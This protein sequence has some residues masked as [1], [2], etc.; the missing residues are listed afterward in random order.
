[1]SKF[2]GPNYY[3]L[4]TYFDA[5]K[6]MT[7]STNGY[8]IGPKK[9]LV[10][11]GGYTVLYENSP[12][13]GYVAHNFTITEIDGNRFK[14]TYEGLESTFS[15]A[16]GSTFD[17]G[18]EFY[19]RKD[20]TF[21]AWLSLSENEDY[22]NYCNQ[23][24]TFLYFG[25]IWPDSSSSNSYVIEFEGLKDFT[26][27]CLP[28]HNQ[29]VGM[30]EWLKVYWDRVHHEVYSMTKNFWSMMDAR[31]IDI[32]W[33]GYIAGIYGIEIT[34]DVLNEISLR[35]W[36]ENLP[37]FLKRVGTYDAL[38]IVWKV[39]VQNTQNKLN[40]YERWGEWCTQTRDAS[41]GGN[42]T[43]TFV[44]HHF[45]EFYGTQPSG[46][47]GDYYYSQYDPSNYPVHTQTAPSTCSPSVTGNY[48]LTPHYKVQLD[49]STEPLGDVFDDETIIS[50]NVITE[51]YNNFE[52]VRPVN[53]YVH[54][55]ELIAPLGTLNNKNFINLYPL[56]SEGYFN[57]SFT[58]YYGVSGG[59]GGEST[60]E[61]Y[62]AT[63]ATTW[64]VNHDLDSPYVIVQVWEI[65]EA[66]SDYRM[67][68]PDEIR[69]IDN[70]NL[71]I[72]FADG[73]RNGIA[74][75][76]GHAS[77]AGISA[78]GT[79]PSGVSWNMVHSLDATTPEGYT[80]NVGPVVSFY[81]TNGYKDIPSESTI[82]SDSTQTA[83][84]AIPQSGGY[85]IRRSE[86]IH[87]QPTSASSWSI[88]HNLS[89]Y[90]IVQ[91]YDWDT[92][93]LIFPEE[94]YIESSTQY[95]KLTINWAN[96]TKG[97]AH[98][99]AVPR[100]V[101]IHTGLACDE[102]GLGICAS[103]NNIGYW[104]VGTGTSTTWNPF[105]EGDLETVA[106]SGYYYSIEDDTNNIY[107]DFIVPEGDND[108]NITEV[109]LFNID[110][111]LIFYSN[112]SGIY[113]LK[114]IQTYFHYRIVKRF[115]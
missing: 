102:F 45:L 98:I 6:S 78:S 65:F 26:L 38:Y 24:K 17:I 20:S 10:S 32:Q 15:A 28:E 71:E 41:G 7:S 72:T 48:V 109:G 56:T 87:S 47:S 11:E 73:D 93:E 36:V 22:R 14:F 8:V 51:L 110:D 2:S 23:E 111:D 60:Y 54:Y 107:I 31:E 99:I 57:T 1:M 52:Y 3:L 112:S 70:N 40:V 88:T 80:S 64:S 50:Q 84:W 101:L 12:D 46:G 39:F 44:D 89:S 35:E 100:S 83:T 105:T 29:T 103:P 95:D 25:K 27:K 86:H 33:L 92:K 5:I 74:L 68:E 53:K 90:V 37:Y 77:T 97:T 85:L 114:E 43:D 30:T 69:I 62:Q 108:I 4:N 16:S 81:D 76:A 75:I 49:L 106:A 19:F 67:I 59:F 66:T 55:E 104:K 113:K 91:C 34:E 42:F 79:I 61:H 18:N 58:A 63:N 82:F 21:H 9:S 96:P 13:R 94:M 115:V